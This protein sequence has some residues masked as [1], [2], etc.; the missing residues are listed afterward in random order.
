MA[1]RTSDSQMQLLARTKKKDLFYFLIFFKNSNH[2]DT[3]AITP[4]RVT[5]GGAHLRGSKAPKKRRSGSGTVSD[6]T[7][8]G[9][10]PMTS[11]ADSGFFNH[12]TNRLIFLSFFQT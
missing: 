9:I 6:L 3:R 5:S 8:L 12:L 1:S 4:K 2:H 7:D 10:E 11:G